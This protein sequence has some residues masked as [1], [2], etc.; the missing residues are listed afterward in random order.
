MGN[1]RYE[2]RVGNFTFQFNC[3]VNNNTGTEVPAWNLW[4]ITA[5]SGFFES[6]KGSSRIVK[7]PLDERSII[8][9]APADVGRSSLDRMVGGSRFK[10]MMGNAFGKVR[11]MLNL[12]NNSASM[13]NSAPMAMAAARPAARRG[14]EKLVRGS[15]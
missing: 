12:N 7:S 2:I 10:N 8:S 3:T 13:A 6:V 15:N 5:N 14:L 4:V 9:A 1:H 11:H